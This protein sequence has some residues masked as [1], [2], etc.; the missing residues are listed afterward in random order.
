[1]CRSE[2]AAQSGPVVQMRPQAGVPDWLARVAPCAPAP[3]PRPQPRKIL[4]ELPQNLHCSVVGTCLPTPELRKVLG[5]FSDADLRRMSDLELHEQGV[6]AAGRHDDAGRAL[7]KALDRRHEA[8]LRKFARA[9][10]GELRQLWCEARQ[11]GDLPGAYWATLTHGQVTQALVHEIFG[12]VH[13]LSHLVGAAN[14]SALSRMAELEEREAELQGRIEKQ[15]ARFAELV[16]EREA[17]ARRL[18]AATVEQAAARALVAAADAAPVSDANGL[19]DRLAA[20]IVRRQRAEQKWQQ[21]REALAQSRSDFAAVSAKEQA[22]DAE[23]AALE[24]LLLAQ[25]NEAA[26]DQTQDQAQDQ[27]QDRARSPAGVPAGSVIL[28]V[29]GRP[30]QVAQIRDHL[31]AGGAELLHHDGGL[32]ERVGMLAGMISRAHL[33]VFPVDCIS[34]GAMHAVKRLCGQA[35]KAYLPL[36]SAGFASFAGGVPALF[37]AEAAGAAA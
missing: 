36:R 30:A 26:R 19:Q 4:W 21:A 25:G 15:Q 32:Q 37:A 3:A 34:H 24:T 5:R 33:V 9:G 23:V 7:H 29:G 31:A 18:D 1:M 27:T 17:L 14:R 16:Q 28:Y 11:H 8:A 2:Q 35:G 20:E 6:M 10:A 12:E 22:L 13:M